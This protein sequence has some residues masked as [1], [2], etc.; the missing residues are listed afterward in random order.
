MSHLAIERFAEL[1]GSEGDA[2]EREHLSGCSTCAAELSAYRRLVALAGDERRRIA[3]PLTEWGSLSSQLRQD[4]LVATK[5]V[6][7]S[8][9]QR[10]TLTARRAAAV[11]VLVGAGTLFGR[12]S[13]GMAPNE[14]VS[15]GWTLKPAPRDAAG[16]RL[17][18]RTGEA[19]FGSS[20]DALAVLQRAQDDYERA[21]AY[22]AVHDTS[23]SETAAEQYRTRLAALDRSAGSFLEALNEAPQDPVINQIYLATLGARE[24][25]LGKLGR[26]LPVGTRLSRF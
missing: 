14:V 3:P 20:D 2:D 10:V 21:A 9:W 12:L 5:P 26:A 13:T 19:S 15:S 1:V 24:A 18:S 23:T 11:I 7:P 6:R 17:V 4:G 8:V 25:T 22:L 16:G